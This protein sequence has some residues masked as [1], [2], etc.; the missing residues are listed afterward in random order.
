MNILFVGLGN[1]SSQIFDFF[2]LRASSDQKFLVAG[3]NLEYLRQR[4]SFT[5]YAAM[6]LGLHPRLDCVQMD[7]QSIDQT[8]HTIWSSR[9]DVIISS[10]TVQPSSAISRLPAPLFEKLRHAGAGPW[11]PLSL[12]LLHKLMQAVKQTGLSP[13]VLNGASPDNV[14]AVLAH[15]GLAP[16]TGFGNLANL[17]P[18]VRKAAASQ[19]KT[20]LGQI[21]VLFYGHNQVAHSLR[22]SGTPGAPFYLAVLVDGKE[23]THRLDLQ[24]LFAALP[25]TTQ[26]EYTQLISAASATAVLDALTQQTPAVVHAPG[27]N[28]LP[29]AYPI[30]ARAGRIEVVLP[31]GLTLEEAVRI[32]QEGQRLDGIE[33]IESDGTVHFTARNMAILKETLGYECLR[34]PLSE[35]EERAQELRTRYEEHLPQ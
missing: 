13:L 27:P 4:T 6:Q 29:G 32:N 5:S 15:V 1:L 30:R 34:M 33:H 26:H 23:A 20:P 35:V 19:L 8:A 17:I 2:L 7:V 21:Q 11:M 22:T 12:V 18:A 3:R 24:A 28:G 25:A 16:T 14:H 10:V 9:P 31:Q